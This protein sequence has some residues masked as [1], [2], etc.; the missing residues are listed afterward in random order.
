MFLLSVLLSQPF[1]DLVG[2]KFT[3][4]SPP[5]PSPPPSVHGVVFHFFFNRALFLQCSHITSVQSPYVLNSNVVNYRRILT[6][7]SQLNK[8]SAKMTLHQTHKQIQ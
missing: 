8:D 7:A 4:V 2:E 3:V 5:P 1:E 6:Q